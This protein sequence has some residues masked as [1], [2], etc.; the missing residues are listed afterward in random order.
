LPLAPNAAEINVEAQKSE[1]RSMLSFTRALITLRN[2]EPALNAGSFDM[3]PAQ[4]GALAYERRSGERRFVIVSDVE[5]KPARVVLP[6]A[7]RIVVC[8]TVDRNGERV[9]GIIDIAAD[10]AAV[11]LLD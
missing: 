1:P 5:S 10:E 7:G 2:A 8:T 4:G 9:A 11:I 6:A 3:L